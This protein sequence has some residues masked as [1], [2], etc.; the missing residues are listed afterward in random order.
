MQQR[1]PGSPQ[2]WIQKSGTPLSEALLLNWP[3]QAAGG[4]YS[5]KSGSGHLVFETEKQKNFSTVLTKADSARG[6]FSK[7][8]FA[9]QFSIVSGYL[10]E[11]AVAGLI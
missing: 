5:A 2:G 8:T 1:N 3:L 6:A 11:D 10:V 7:V 4:L 9:P